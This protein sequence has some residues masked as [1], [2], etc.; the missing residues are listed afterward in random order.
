MILEGARKWNDG[1]CWSKKKRWL[2]SC[3]SICQSKICS[4]CKKEQHYNIVIRNLIFWKE[5]RFF[6]KSMFQRNFN[7]GSDAQRKMAPMSN[8]TNRASAKKGQS[9]KNFVT[10]DP[11]TDK[12]S[13]HHRFANSSA[14]KVVEDRQ[15]EPFRKSRKSQQLKSGHPSSSQE[16]N[17]PSSSQEN[18]RP[19]KLLIFKVDQYW[20]EVGKLLARIW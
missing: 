6:A 20:R 5:G 9:S 10:R 11:R 14:T 1:S 8:I 7:S 2:L 19:Q 12:C 18:N 4:K 13:P 3:L 17:H 16:D 15:R